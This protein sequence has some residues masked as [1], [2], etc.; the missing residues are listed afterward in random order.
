MRGIT[1]SATWMSAV[2]V[3]ALVIAGCA[4]TEERPPEK[5]KPAAVK[6]PSLP[7]DYPKAARWEP[8]HPGNY[9]ASD[10]RKIDMVVIHTVEG[11]K[12]GCISWFKNPKSQATAHY[13]VGFDGEVVQMVREK[14]IAWHAG[15]WDYNVRAVGIEHEGHAGKNEWTEAQLK[16]SSELT[17]YLCRKYGIPIDRRHIIGHKEVPKQDHWDP[18]PQFD[19]DNYMKLVIQTL[20]VR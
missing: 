19:W 8:S 5:P 10:S 2:S 9:T 6:S 16:A 14:D 1:R 3:P 18:G 4:E 7:V 12:T 20:G 13:V 17:A 11:T 15:N